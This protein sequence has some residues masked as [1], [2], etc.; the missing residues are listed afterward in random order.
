MDWHVAVE[1][2]RTGANIYVAGYLAECAS[3]RTEQVV[4]ALQRDTRVIRLDLRAV[5]IIDPVAFVTV[6]RALNRW[7]D[8]TEGQLRI[9]FPERSERPERP[10]LHLIDAAH[11]ASVPRRGRNTIFDSPAAESAAW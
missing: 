1:A 2:H 10:R 8:A 7:R 9:Q 6:V 5:S 4:A 3:E 11:S